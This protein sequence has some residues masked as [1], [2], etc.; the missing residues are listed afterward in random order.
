MYHYYHIIVHSVNV[1]RLGMYPSIYLQM[2]PGEL[3]FAM[4]VESVL[5]SLP[6]PEYRQLIVEV[7]MVC[8][9]W[10]RLNP[11]E[12][13]PHVMVLDNVIRCA[14]QL[15]L[16]D[17]VGK[18]LIVIFVLANGGVRMNLIIKNYKD[19]SKSIAHCTNHY[20]HYFDVQSIN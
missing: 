11:Q 6:N 9:I 3:K 18:S 12:K 1:K 10:V 5:N 19:R 2:T 4:R 15:F 7:L 14:N 16:E 13:Y 20:Y 17:Q 8:G